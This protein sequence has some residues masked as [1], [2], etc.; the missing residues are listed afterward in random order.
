MLTFTLK[1][2]RLDERGSIVGTKQTELE[3]DTSVGGRQDAMNPVELLL[4]ALAACMLKG[5]ERLAPTIGFSFGEIAID[6]VAQRPD[7][8]A[9][10][11]TI[12]YIIRIV[13]DEPDSKLE[14]LH[15]NLQKQGTIYNTVKLG[16]NLSGVIRRV[17]RA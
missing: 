3:I 9:R 2:N 17:E 14:L 12:T 5:V 7:Q 10:I 16:T 15:K 8:E 1:A 13:T 11:D 4:A 6:F